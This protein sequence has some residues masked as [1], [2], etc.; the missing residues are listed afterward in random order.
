MV[1]RGI[2]NSITLGF[3]LWLPFVVFACMGQT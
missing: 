3:L 1:T 2:F